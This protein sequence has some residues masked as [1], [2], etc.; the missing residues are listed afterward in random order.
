MWDTE[1]RRYIDASGGAAV[2]NIGHGVAEVAQAMAEQAADVAYVHGTMFTTDVLET[3]S[4]Q[5]AALVP[6]PEP[7]FFYMTSGSE[8]VETAI[9]FARQVQIARGEPTRELIISRWGSYHGATMGA[10]ALTGRTKMLRLE[11]HFHGWFDSVTYPG[12]PGVL[13]AD[14]EINSV[15]IP[16]D[17]DLIERELAKGEYAVLFTEGGGAH[18][19]GQYPLDRD[20][21][22]A[23][24]DLTRRYGTVWVIDD[25][26]TSENIIKEFREID[27]LYVAD[28][29]H[30]SASAAK[31]ANKRKGANPGHTGEEEYNF[32]LAVTF[33]TN[34]CGFWITTESSNT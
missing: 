9:K 10:L 31:V 5:L 18:M 24:R 11:E 15:Y 6:M 20:L 21:V 14:N 34:S 4:E 17:L 32:F 23:L 25:D 19:G 16:H 28:G 27:F 2:V 12:T 1:G 3:H 29:H 22:H 33:P 26:K 7:R 30:R 13:P 8:A